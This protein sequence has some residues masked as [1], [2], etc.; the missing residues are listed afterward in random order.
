MTG[1]YGKINQ[2]NRIECVN[3]IFNGLK[4]SR[5]NEESFVKGR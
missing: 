1:T 4:S 5:I 2:M 3:R